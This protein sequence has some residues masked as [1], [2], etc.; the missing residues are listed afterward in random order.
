MGLRNRL[1]RP[2]RP[3]E[4]EAVARS[5]FGKVCGVGGGSPSTPSPP[6]AGRQAGRRRVDPPRDGIGAYSYGN[7]VNVVNAVNGKPCEGETGRFEGQEGGRKSGRV[8]GLCVGKCRNVVNA[9]NGK[10]AHLSTT[11]PDAGKPRVVAAAGAAR[12]DRP[13]PKRRAP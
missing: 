11:A 10:D 2:R 13:R 9:V 12:P 8:L 6:R 7:A 4:R 5:P 1:R 3:A